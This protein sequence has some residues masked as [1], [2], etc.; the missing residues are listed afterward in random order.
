[1]LFNGAFSGETNFV[2][3]KKGYWY[4]PRYKIHQVK[5]NLYFRPDVYLLNL[6]LG[7]YYDSASSRWCSHHKKSGWE[8][9]VLPGV[10]FKSRSELLSAFISKNLMVTRRA[11]RWIVRGLSHLLSPFRE[12]L[13]QRRLIRVHRIASRA[14]IWSGMVWILYA[15]SQH[16]WLKERHDTPWLSHF[17]GGKQTTGHK[18]YYGAP[19]F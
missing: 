10:E 6:F 13:L 18:I 4:W 2:L 11:S 9:L 8:G 5:V 3:Q 17:F 7:Q 19:F 14:K 1:V 15:E 12:V 16:M